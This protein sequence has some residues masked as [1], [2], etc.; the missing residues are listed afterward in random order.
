MIRLSRVVYTVIVAAIVSTAASAQVQLGVPKYASMGGGPADKINLGSLNADYQ[1]PV[2]HKAGRGLAFNFDLNFDSSVWE[3]VYTGSGWTWG[4]LADLG[5]SGSSIDI[6]FLQDNLFTDGVEYDYDCV[7]YYDGLGSGHSFPQCAA[8]DFINGIDYPIVDSVT[9]DGSGYTLSYDPFVTGVGQLTTVNGN[10]IIPRNEVPL[11]QGVVAGSDIDRNGNEIS[12]SASGSFTDTLGTT[13]LTESGGCTGLTSCTPYVMGYTAPSGGTANVTVNFKTYTVRSN[14][15]CSGISEFGATSIDLVDRI[16]L[17]DASYYQF[18]Y[19]PTPGFS[20][21]VTARLASV[22]LPTGGTMSYAYSGGHNG[23]EC[24]DGTTAGF[25]RTTPDGTWTYARTLTGGNG[26]TTTVT[27][28]TGNQTVISFQKDSA[29]TNNTYEYFEVQR[30]V[31]QGSA[32]SGT[33]LQT[34]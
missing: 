26:S 25:T 15:G 27:D 23:I 3:P 2:R 24:A 33:L 14:F 5:W 28:P 29:S 18:T 1:F 13:A 20:G 8:F 12:I 21:D 7:V 22:R 19:E 32:A 4:L 9:T 34:T 11:G 10:S 17:P 31:Y 6:G 30:Q 16:T